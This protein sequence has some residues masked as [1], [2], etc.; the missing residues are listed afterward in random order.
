MGLHGIEWEALSGRHGL[1]ANG[2]LKVTLVARWG[3]GGFSITVGYGAAGG[4]P[5]RATLTQMHEASQLQYRPSRVVMWHVCT[6]ARVHSGTCAQWH[7]S[8]VG[9]IHSGTCAYVCAG[10]RQQGP[11]GT[12]SRASSGVQ[13]QRFRLQA[14]T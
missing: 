12:R 9:R 6:V 13:R 3:N 10:S 11:G 5:A 4:C 8:T 14:A 1:G 7:V 2:A